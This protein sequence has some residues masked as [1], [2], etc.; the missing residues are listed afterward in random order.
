MISKFYFSRT[1]GVIVLTTFAVG[2]S[3]SGVGL[4]P[5]LAA[6]KSKAKPTEANAAANP[7]PTGQGVLMGMAID[8]ITKNPLSGVKM[9]FRND[10]NKYEVTTNDQGEY[11]IPHVV[12]GSYFV[13]VTKPGYKRLANKGLLVKAD[14]TLKVNARLVSESVQAA[15]PAANNAAAAGKS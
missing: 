4:K 7:S 11:N 9:I 12:A 15:P 5:A 3:L 10:A 6:R 8:K 2:A 1:L 14:K 13:E